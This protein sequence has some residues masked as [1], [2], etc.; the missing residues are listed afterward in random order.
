MCSFSLGAADDQVSLCP[1]TEGVMRKSLRSSVLF[2]CYEVD[3]NACKPSNHLRHR[4]TSPTNGG[5]QIE[6][7]E[8]ETNFAAARNAETFDPAAARPRFYLLSAQLLNEV[9]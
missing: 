5:Q 2:G 8:T 9:M 1:I 3:N 7:T 6:K 4:R